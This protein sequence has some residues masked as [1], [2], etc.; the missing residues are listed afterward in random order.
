MHKF[1]LESQEAFKRGDKGLAKDLS[2]KSKELR[3]EMEKLNKQA[4]EWIF[5]GVY[6]LDF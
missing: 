6:L 1:S 2:N 3:A 4:S 5:T